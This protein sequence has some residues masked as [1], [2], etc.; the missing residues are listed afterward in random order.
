MGRR[1]TTSKPLDWHNQPINQPINK[2]GDG[3]RGRTTTSNKAAEQATTTREE[4]RE[5]KRKD[6]QAPTGIEPVISCLLGKRFAI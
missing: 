1:Q 4:G 6:L 5:A 2:M 3:R